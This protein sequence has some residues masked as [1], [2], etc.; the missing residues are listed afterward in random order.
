MNGLSFPDQKGGS[1]PLLQHAPLEFSSDKALDSSLRVDRCTSQRKRHS[2]FFYSTLIAALITMKPHRARRFLRKVLEFFHLSSSSKR[3]VKAH[4]KWVSNF[5]SIHYQ[6]LTSGLVLSCG[7]LLPLPPHLLF[8]AFVLAGDVARLKLMAKLMIL[9]SIPLGMIPL[10]S[11][12][13]PAANWS[14]AS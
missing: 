8:R 14:V 4:N 10:K 2:S 3:E 6:K 11:Q 13:P 1:T 5:C 9:P 12:S 7:V